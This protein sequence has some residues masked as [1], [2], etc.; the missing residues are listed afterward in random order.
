VLETIDPAEVVAIRIL[1]LI[2]GPAGLPLGYLKYKGL[3]DL[4]LSP[5]Y[6]WWSQ[7]GSNR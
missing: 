5:S 3:S 6:C 7:P 1:R 2:A 4:S